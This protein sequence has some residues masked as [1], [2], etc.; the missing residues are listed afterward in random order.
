MITSADL[1]RP[2]A[3]SASTHTVLLVD[4]DA[5][6]LKLGR[7]RLIEAG[8]AV[9]TASG[10]DEA[11]RK[12]LLSAPDVVLS[13][14]LMDDL[15]GFALCRLL[16]GEPS[17]EGVPV[18]LLSA[19]YGGDPDQALATRVGAFALVTR[20]ADFQA[21]LS[22]LCASLASPCR[23]HAGPLGPTLCEQH[24]RSNARQVARLLDEA[25][26]VEERYRT[27]FENAHGP[28]TVLTPDGVMLEVNERWAAIL[29]VPASTLVGR[30]I[31][32]L[33][34][35]ERQARLTEGFRRSI[36]EG[37]GTQHAVELLRA[38]GTSI[39]MDFANRLMERDGH[40]VVLSVGHDVSAQVVAARN[41]AAAE[42]RYRSLL[43]R[44][45]DV[46]WTCSMDGAVAFV[47]AN[48]ERL[49]GYTPAEVAA[50][51]L[52]GQLSF[53]H[54]D[55]RAAALAAFRLY[56]EDGR[57]L[58]L[59]YRSRHKDGRWIWLRLRANGTYL[60]DGVRYA[61]GM[62]TDVSE[63][64]QLEE[65]L[66]QAQKMEALGQLTGGV[67]HDFNNILASILANSHFLLEDLD[68]T[69]PRRTDADEIRIAA[70]RAAA[71]VKQLLAFG[72]RQVMRM[73]PVDLNAVVAGLEPMLRRLIGEDIEFA[74]VREGALGSAQADVSQVEQVILNLVVNARDAMPSGGRLVIET[75]NVEFEDDYVGAHPGAQ[76]GRYVMVAVTDTGCGMDAE[77]RQHIFEPF[78][79]TKEQ[80]RGTGLGLSTC[81][82]I[83][84]QSGGHIWV[85]SEPGRGTVFKIYLPRVD[86]RSASVA[87]R[88]ERTDLHGVETV[89]VIEDDA[90]LRAS[91]D[92]MLTARGYRVIVARDGAEALALSLEHRGGI[93]LVLSDVVMP[94]A[95]GPEVVGL[96]Q[97]SV[98]PVRTLFMSGYTDH[99]A[100]RSGALQGEMNFIQKPFAPAAL[101]RKV[102]EVLDA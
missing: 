49:T 99:A 33:V 36:E 93:D 9:E 71:L 2:R 61:D 35:P 84:K 57:A 90:G 38:D 12:A 1:V 68:E 58:D 26:H 60:R 6:Q 44:I 25:R 54:P 24:L 97:A 78:F 86:Q 45:P 50:R 98:G 15:D 96:M 13:D 59:E 3:A 17:L 70:E 100:F 64:R 18:V 56:T 65:T 11:L 87:P 95:S 91:V 27:L 102:R 80:G 23:A 76:P 69:D 47:T 31:R 62:L 85:Y 53:V 19:H 51:D 63:R 72:R 46:I 52:E 81:Y 14:V 37:A 41:L 75:A 40:S 16:R 89:L 73:T 79:T 32:E 39:Y 20:T 94:G 29:G 101:A 10:G 22:A 30:H 48:I 74:V 67:A 34:A 7:L 55:D 28:I 8:F 92:R 83:V 5:T 88:L 42:Q 66:R 77:V 82:G 21:E 43:D 4:D